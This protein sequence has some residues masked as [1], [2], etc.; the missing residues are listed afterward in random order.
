MTTTILRKGSKSTLS[1]EARIR[2]VGPG[3]DDDYVSLA[4][5][6]AARRVTTGASQNELYRSI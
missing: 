3:I 5:I 6:D 1:D 2:P 4:R